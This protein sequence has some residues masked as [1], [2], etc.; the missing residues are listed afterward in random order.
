MTEKKTKELIEKINNLPHVETQRGLDGQAEKLSE[1]EIL[2][3][4]DE[5]R[6][7]TSQNETPNSSH[8]LDLVEIKEQGK[9]MFT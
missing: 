6:S 2:T 1:K 8:S 7:D 9:E 3:I 5:I 4:L